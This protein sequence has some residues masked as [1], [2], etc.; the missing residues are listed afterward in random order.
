MPPSEGWSVAALLTAVAALVPLSVPLGV[1]ALVQRGARQRSRVLAATALALCLLWAAATGWFVGART[2]LVDDLR[3]VWQGIPASRLDVGDC[4][5]A[6][7]GLLQVRVVPCDGPHDGEVYFRQVLADGPY[8]GG[9]A[10]VGLAHETCARRLDDLAAALNRPDLTSYVFAV[11]SQW[12]WADGDR[13][14]VCAVEGARL[15]EPQLR[16][17]GLGH[18]LRRP[19]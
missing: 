5:D 2:T 6:V 18:D 17:R 9:G 1:Y 13:A 19:A 10:L 7:G 14:V 4:F 3:T 11:P 16:A 8:P 12:S 15:A